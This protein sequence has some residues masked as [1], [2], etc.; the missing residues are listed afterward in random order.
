M[1]F[2]ISNFRLMIYFSVASVFSFDGVLGEQNNLDMG[3]DCQEF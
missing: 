3:I 2:S 1:S